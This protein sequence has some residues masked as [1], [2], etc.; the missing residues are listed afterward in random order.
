MAFSRRAEGSSPR[1]AGLNIT[2]RKFIGVDIK[3]ENG[4]IRFTR[5]G[6]SVKAPSFFFL[7]SKQKRPS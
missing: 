3:G 6:S 5:I 7:I 2:T 4:I 1:A